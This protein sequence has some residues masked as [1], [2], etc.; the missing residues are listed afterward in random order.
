MLMLIIHKYNLEEALKTGKFIFHKVGDE[1][2]VLED[3]NTFVS[4]TDDKE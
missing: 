3:I 4:F 2:H 1:V